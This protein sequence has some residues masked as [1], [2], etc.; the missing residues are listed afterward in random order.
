MTEILTVIPAM[1]SAMS[2]ND[3]IDYGDDDFSE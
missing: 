1:L 3:G 2:M